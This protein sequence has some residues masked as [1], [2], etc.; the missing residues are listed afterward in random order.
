M[1][2]NNLAHL[3]IILCDQKLKVLF[4]PRSKKITMNKNYTLKTIEIIH[5]LIMI[6]YKHF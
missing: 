1:K 6:Q 3:I 5:I 2:L 4:Q